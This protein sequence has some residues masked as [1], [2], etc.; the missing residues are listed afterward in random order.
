MKIFLSWSGEV[1]HRVALTLKD[2][3]P[4]VLHS[5]KPFVSS[6]DIAKGT[7]W[8]IEL[9][10]ELEDTDYGILCVTRANVQAPWLNF[11][12]GALS[13][14][15]ACSRVSPFLLDLK[16]AELEGPLAC[17]QATSYDEHDV[18]KL[19]SSLNDAT[20]SSNVSSNAL[21]EGL[22][23]ALEPLQQEAVRRMFA[24]WWPNLKDALDPLVSGGVDSYT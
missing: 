15:I 7:R 8:A 14:S 5:A 17:F 24:Q 16:K 2:W 21:V 12:A 18:Y 1:S 11:E 20:F 13:K 23:T 10:H 22:R 3:L 6:E 4:F 9:A 19:V